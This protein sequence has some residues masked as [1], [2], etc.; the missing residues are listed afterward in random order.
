MKSKKRIGTFIFIMIAT[1][2]I[3]A[4]SVSIGIAVSEYIK[5]ENEPKAKE[6]TIKKEE[7]TQD[8]KVEFKKEL[9]TLKDK[10]ENVIVENKRTIPNIT[11]EKY[12]TQAEK[13]TDFLIKIS[14]E[15]WEKIKVSS[16][17]Y[18]SQN[19]TEKVGVT[20]LLS[21]LEQNDK[22]FTF[23]Y[24][25]SGIIGGV[26]YEDRTGYSFNTQTGE[27]LNID[28]ISTNTN[29][30]INICY[31]KLLEYISS[32]EYAN[33]LDST[34]KVTLKQLIS[35]NGVWYLTKDGLSFSFPRYSFGPGS[36]GVIS[37]MISYD[38]LGNLISPNYLQ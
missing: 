22:Y 34:W 23:A 3:V 37:Y 16:D 20:Y 17:E 27:L 8:F 15:Q 25:N 6:E 26:N 9:Y 7:T 36:I 38:D 24:D 11:S 21:V 32:K 14:D 4:A 30:L 12:Q 5:N 29:D 31:T 1:A 13:I 19:S 10:N 28:D 2:F 35:K 18:Y 33:E